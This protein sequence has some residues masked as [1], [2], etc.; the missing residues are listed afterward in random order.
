MTKTEIEQAATDY[1]NSLGTSLLRS[2]ILTKRISF[3]AGAEFINSRQP[4]TDE[5]M[6]KFSVWFRNEVIE[7][8]GDNGYVLFSYRDV[9]SMEEV[10][11]LWKES[12]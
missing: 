2:T 9:Y 7:V 5:D 8:T 4:Y 12:K 1:I 10:I 6:R 11:K 3:I